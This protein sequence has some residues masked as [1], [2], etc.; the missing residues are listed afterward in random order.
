MSTEHN[1]F[2]E[3]G[4][5]FIPYVHTQNGFD[6]KNKT[7]SGFNFKNLEKELYIITPLKKRVIK[8]EIANKP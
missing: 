4:Y 3:F 5:T 8:N 7:I 1:K 2:Q 6:F